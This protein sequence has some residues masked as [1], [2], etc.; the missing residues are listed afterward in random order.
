MDESRHWQREIFQ[1]DL[2]HQMEFVERNG[3]IDMAQDAFKALRD[4]GVI[5]AEG[6]V[7]PQIFETFQAIANTG[8]VSRKSTGASRTAESQEPS[9]NVSSGSMDGPET[10]VLTPKSKRGPRRIPEERQRAVVEAWERLDRDQFAITLA[11]FLDEWFD[12]TGGKL[13]VPP[14]TFYGWRK[15]FMNS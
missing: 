12:S 2:A 11:E 7:R 13:N 6:R 5:D 15:K 10:A 9:E 14:S 4:S 8:S 1:R 3:V